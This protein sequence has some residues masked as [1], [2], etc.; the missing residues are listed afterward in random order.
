MR[1]SSSPAVPSSVVPGSG[2][3]D[4]QAMQAI[5]ISNMGASPSARYLILHVYFSDMSREDGDR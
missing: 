4:A 3:I 2:V 1:S 5:C